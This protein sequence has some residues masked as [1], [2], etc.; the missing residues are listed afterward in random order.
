M[1]LQK[2]LRGLLKDQF[3]RF[4]LYYLAAAAALYFTHY[5]GS[6]LPFYAKELAEIIE[7]GTES[8]D[9]SIF[10]YLAL[11]ILVFRTS[12][13][14]L[15]FYPA[16]VLE[17]DMRVNILKR[18]EETNPYRYKKYS[19]GQLFQV[20]YTDTEQ[21]RAL[22]GFAL[23]QMGNV[24][25]AL[26]VLVPKLIEFN[27]ELTLALI[28]MVV[29]S[30][31]FA[32][33]VGKTRVWHR[34]SADIQ[35]DIQN[36]IMEA[37]NGK[38][39]IKNFHAES[40]FIDLFKFISN[41]E[42]DYSYKAGKAIS[43]SVPFIPLGIGLSFLW[44]AHIIHQNGLEGSA[45]VLFSGFVFL[46]LEPLMFLSWIGVVF[47]AS[48]AAWSRID[49]FIHQIDTKDEFE[50]KLDDVAIIKD[51]DFEK[52]K[53]HFWDKEISI[54]YLKGGMT[55]LVGNTGCGKTE[56]LTQLAH[57]LKKHNKSLCYIGQNPYIYHDNIQHNIFLGEENISEQKIE[58][59]Y[60]L[61]SIFG[62]S[63]LSNS[64]SGLLNLEVG[65]HGKRLSGGQQKR[66]SLV[67]SLLSDSEYLIWD[68][69]FS[70]ID[71][72]LEKEI[73]SQLHQERLLENKTIIMS[74][75]RL[76]T[77]K[78]SDYCILLEAQGGVQEHGTTLN[79]LDKEQGKTKIYEFFE[80]QMV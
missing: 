80:K 14:L 70:S 51:Q 77:V 71:V 32:I 18:L 33:I 52:I 54:K 45:L 34:K 8:I 28:P 16:R 22:V 9:T 41:K 37:F 48:L 78:H 39:T 75:H 68:D 2:G 27:Q 65:E 7:K 6:F 3:K 79:L 25:I 36:N 66:L 43:V 12:S 73:L 76:S 40:S 35:G 57:V 72:I 13:R 31:L 30:L 56:V 17:R 59:A 4:F 11:G 44:G 53:V 5:M 21:I 29:G 38:R 58:K 50:V 1:E 63:F 55:V 26:I 23:L 62:L 24:F 74:S 61:L 67:K 46:F 64:K 20:L 69:P 47:T 10:F 19:E 15:F 60:H 49:E 42:L